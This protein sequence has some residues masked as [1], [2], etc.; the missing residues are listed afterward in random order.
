MW[1]RDSSQFRG[2]RCEVWVSRL[3]SGVQGPSMSR[4]QVAARSPATYVQI[5][6]TWW[7]GGVLSF[8]TF[9]PDAFAEGV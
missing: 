9:K 7:Q 6:N 8:S 2:F 1:E 3:A 4:V 5:Q